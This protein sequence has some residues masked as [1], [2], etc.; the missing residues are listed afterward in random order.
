MGTPEFAVPS[1]KLLLQ[2]GYHIAAVVTAPDSYGGRGGK[3]LIQSAV[4]KFSV[5]HHLK[6]LQP[7]KLRDAHFIETL[8]A[9][10]A[11]LFIVVAFRMLPKIV[12]DLP[13]YGTFNLHGSL[14]PK[15][16]GAAPINHAIM[17][18]EKETGVTTFKLKHEIDTGDLVYQAHIP[19]EKEDTAGTIHDKLMV[20]GAKTILKTVKSIE[21]GSLELI[22]QN[23]ETASDAP[24]LNLETTMINFNQNAEIV[25]NFIRGL[26]PYPGAWT[27]I[28]QKL[29]KIIEA[30]Y[31]LE[32]TNVLA[33]S[34]VVNGI[35]VL[36]I[37]C[38]DGWIVIK[39]L[40]MEGKK[41]MD[42]KSFLLGRR[43]IHKNN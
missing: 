4:K 11:N 26:S 15:Y 41:M 18:G 30:D 25:F 23:S 42:V 36:K 3:E 12:W 2:N 22:P 34:V 27:R 24:K 21:D 32:N 19:I 37:K 7:V 1:L 6:I 31:Y 16:R 33:G 8:K 35:Q 40:K 28:D 5:D 38:L 10:D 14:L 20:L 13:K 17:R 39:K 29:T 9:L 43:T